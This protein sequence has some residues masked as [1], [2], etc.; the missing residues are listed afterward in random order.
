[1]YPPIQLLFMGLLLI[2]G[3]IKCR[4]TYYYSQS[5]NPDETVRD[6]KPFE[7]GESGSG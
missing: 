2:V 1:M 5:Y 4:K 6:T 7:L 3:L